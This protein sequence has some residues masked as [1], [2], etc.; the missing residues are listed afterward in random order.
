MPD[1]M[2]AMGHASAHLTLA[3]YAGA[4]DLGDRERAALRALAQG[5]D[6]DPAQTPPSGAHP[7]GQRHHGT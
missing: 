7:S 6:W 3:V 4:M 1:T 5:A 2:R